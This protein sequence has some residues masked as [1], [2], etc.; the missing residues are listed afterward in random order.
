MKNSSSDQYYGGTGMAKSAR[1]YLH[2]NS[3][4]DGR[5]TNPLVKNCCERPPGSKGWSL[6][7]FLER[8]KAFDPHLPVFGPTNPEQNFRLKRKLIDRKA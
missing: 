2:I 3:K 4:P 6:D 8:A 5:K 7:A 1:R